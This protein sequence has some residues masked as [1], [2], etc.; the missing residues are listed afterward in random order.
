MSK[1]L[2]LSGQDYA[3]PLSFDLGNTKLNKTVDI[4][5]NGVSASTDQF[6]RVCRL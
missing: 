5:N 1:P 4:G 3:S 2:R 6:G